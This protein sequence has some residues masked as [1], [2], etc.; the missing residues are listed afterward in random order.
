MF[1]RHVFLCNVLIYIP[2]ILAYIRSLKNNWLAAVQL[3][4]PPASE[5][6]L[7]Y[8]DINPTAWIIPAAQVTTRFP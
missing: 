2:I 6:E 1:I 3:I 7:F 8:P 5:T 4:A